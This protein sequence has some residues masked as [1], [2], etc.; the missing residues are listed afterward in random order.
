MTAMILS[1][2][3]L[4]L[5][6]EMLFANGRSA[7]RLSANDK[8]EQRWPMGLRSAASGLFARPISTQKKKT[9]K[10]DDTN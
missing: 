7:K 3:F 8:T 10:K 9:K 6:Q 4:I 5:G 2:N 1:R